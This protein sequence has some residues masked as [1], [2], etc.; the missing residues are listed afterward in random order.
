LNVVGATAGLL[1]E[2]DEAQDV[3]PDKWPQDLRTM[4][5]PANVTTVLWG[6]AWTSDTLLAQTIRHLQR[7]Q[8]Q[9]GRRRDFK[10]DAV[11]VG[12]D[13]PACVAYVAGEVQASVSC[14]GQ[15][16]FIAATRSV[17]TPRWYPK[18][19]ANRLS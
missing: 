13:V 2:C 7:V 15:N 17:E 6:I 5:A 11:R 10:Y 19:V 16:G 1:L 8:A 9:D 3:R 4:V 14:W 12:A 18:P